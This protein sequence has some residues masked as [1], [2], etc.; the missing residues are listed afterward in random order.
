MNKSFY[1]L[2]PKDRSERLQRRFQRFGIPFTTEHPGEQL[3]MPTDHVA[4]VFPDL[5]AQQYWQVHMTFGENG[6]PYPK[7][8][9]EIYLS[10]EVY[11]K[12]TN[13]VR[14]LNRSE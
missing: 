11:L 2:V 10:K 12:D 5:P 6:S 3:L 4:F 14:M 13:C 8:I 7:T 9:N 1:Y